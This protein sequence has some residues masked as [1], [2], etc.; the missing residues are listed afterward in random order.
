MEYQRSQVDHVNQ[1]LENTKRELNTQ[2][3]IVN[4]LNRQIG[5]LQQALGEKDGQITQ[6]NAVI[7]EGDMVR[8]QL[9]NCIQELKGNLR[10]YC[11]VRPQLSSDNEGDANA[12]RFLA[13]EDSLEVSVNTKTVTGSEGFKAHQFS[14]DRVCAFMCVHVDIQA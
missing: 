2:M 7:K 1:N 8:R 12:I 4:S 6:M 11:R 3:F 14:F 10:V 5:V 9:H 13:D